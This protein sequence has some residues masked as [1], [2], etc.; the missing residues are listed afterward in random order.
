MGK[1]LKKPE[2]AKLMYDFYHL[3]EQRLSS[4]ISSKRELIIALLMEGVTAED[5]FSQ[6][7]SVPVKKK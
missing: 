5:A 2:A 6:A 4:T 1:K 7:S 3:N